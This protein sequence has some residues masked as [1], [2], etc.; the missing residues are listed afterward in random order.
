MSVSRVCA[1]LSSGY[2]VLIQ[3]SANVLGKVM[4]DSTSAW[5]AVLT[6]KTRK[7]LVTPDLS[8]V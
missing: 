8:L 5:A 1:D 7:K 4:E 6:W 2:S 3:L